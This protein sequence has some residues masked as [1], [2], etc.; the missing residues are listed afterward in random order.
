MSSLEYYTYSPFSVGFER[1]FQQAS[2][3]STGYP[4]HNIVKVNDDTYIIEL[5][6][7]GLKQKD[8]SIT[9]NP[10]DSTLDISYE[11]N[12]ETTANRE[13]VHSGISA[14]SFKKS[15]SLSEYI[16]VSSANMTDGIL[17]IELKRHVPEEKKPRRIEITNS[18]QL[19][20]EDV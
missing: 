8:I 6:L 20:L 4:P 10:K 3:T 9:F 16:E 11:K 1:L 12:N 13:Y 19:L 18:A 7:A 14:R 5:A 2:K 15:F 17:S